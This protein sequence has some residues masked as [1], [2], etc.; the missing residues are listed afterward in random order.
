MAPKNIIKLCEFWLKLCLYIENFIK[1]ALLNVLHNVNNR[2]S[3]QGLPSDPNRLYN[4]LRNHLAK[5][6]KLKDKKIIKSDQWLLLFPVN[7]QTDS[8]KFDTTLIVLLIKNCTTFPSPSEGWKQKLP[9]ATDTTIGAFILRASE[10]RNFIIHYA[11]PDTLEESEF[12]KIWSQGEK[13]LNGLG[14][15]EDT[16]GLKD[17]SL[18]PTRVDY[19]RVFLNHLQCCQKQ[20]QR[21]VD[22]NTTDISNFQGLAREVIE[23][24]EN[25]SSIKDC[26][27]NLKEDVNKGKK[28]LKV[29]IADKINNMLARIHHLNETYE[30]EIAELNNQVVYLE[31]GIKA[32]TNIL[33]DHEERLSKLE[34]EGCHSSFSEKVATDVPSY[35]LFKNHQSNL[36]VKFDEN[37][38]IQHIHATITNNSLKYSKQ[39]DI[40]T[41]YVVE[42]KNGKLLLM[43][44]TSNVFHMGDLSITLKDNKNKLACVLIKDIEPATIH[45]CVATKHVNVL[46]H[47]SSVISK[48]IKSIL[49]KETKEADVEFICGGSLQRMSAKE[50]EEYEKDYSCRYFT[51]NGKCMEEPLQFPPPICNQTSSV[52]AQNIKNVILKLKYQLFTIFTHYDTKDHIQFLKLNE[53]FSL[54]NTVSNDNRILLVFFN[55]IINIRYT[56]AT[57]AIDIQDEFKAGETDLKEL[58]IINRK[59]FKH[60]NWTVINVVAAPNFEI[61]QDAEV[62]INCNLLCKKTLSK[63]RIIRDFFSNI[64]KKEQKKNNYDNSK[65]QYITTVSKIMCFMA[66]RKALYSV[67]SLSDNIHDQ[68]SSLILTIQQLRILYSSYRKKIITGPLGS[69]K[70]V[71]A[72]SHMEL[73]Y[74]HSENNSAIYYVVWDDKTLLKQ[75]VINH[76]KRFKCKKNVE[77]IVTD[78]VELAKNLKMQKVPTPSQL[79]KSL[80]KKHGD[81][82]LHFIIDEFNGEMLGIEEALS[83]KQYFKMEARLADSYIVFLPQSIEKHRS[84]VSHETITKHEKYKYEETGLEFFKLDRAMRTSASI[85]QFLKAFEIKA[86]EKN[87]VIKLPVQE[88]SQKNN[89]PVVWQK[90]TSPLKQED[91]E[92][93]PIR[94]DLSQDVTNGNRLLDKGV[95]NNFEDPIDIDRVAATI[96][97]EHLSEDVRT[98]INFQFNSAAFIGHN[99]KGTK[100][101][102]IHPESNELK[103]EELIA[104]ITLV[105]QHLSL[106]YNTKRLF[107]YN[108]FHQMTIFYRL[109][110]LLDL[111][112][113][114]YDE[115]TDWKIF[116]E[117]EEISNLLQYSSYNILTTPEGCRG[118]E[119]SESIC[120]IENNDRTL[121]HLT[122]ES[123]SRATQNLIIVSTSNINQSKL[124]FSTGHII[125]E[126]L[127][128]YLIE[129][130]V[131]HSKD[132]NT[133]RPYTYSNENNINKVVFNIN[134]QSWQF[135]ELM[136]NIKHIN[137]PQAAPVITNVR[138][139]IF[140]NLHLPG[141]V[142]NVACSYLSDKSCELS[143]QHNAD[144]YT[145]K[146]R[147]NNVSDWKVLAS[148]ITS[149][150]WIVNDISIGENCTFSVVARNRVGQSDDS[151]FSYHHKT[152]AKVE[153]VTYTF[154][155]I[156]KIIKS[157]DINKLKKL[158]SIHPN[159]VHMRDEYERTPLM[160]TVHFTNN[161]SMVEILISYGS[162]VWAEDDEKQNSYHYAAIVGRHTI[163][164]MLCRHDVTNIN[165]GD[166]DNNTPLHWAAINGYISCVDVLLRYENI[167]VTIE[168]EYGYT[169]YD[170]AGRLKNEQN[171]EIIRR[172]IKEYEAR[173][174]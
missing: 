145:V 41:D 165:R 136:K 69:G 124:D 32:N 20:L 44:F 22:E 36:V 37:F 30:K 66:T 27:S 101:L 146:K 169:A 121:K 159:I 105:L 43:I 77:V 150:F 78:I 24:K 55:T 47:N 164:D 51:I 11:N 97:D 63:E 107:I 108:T 80:V 99:I 65:E 54:N 166:D 4:D 28:E 70:T 137:H 10:F 133:D 90:E 161:T 141:K 81:K 93:L 5:L 35:T 85:F 21:I 48:H 140:K 120:L 158:L 96:Q 152:P 148:G 151:I 8:S 25:T 73:A 34:K 104:M 56:D 89:T 122:L 135:K 72:L 113:F 31:R 57:N 39:L 19:F 82:K 64:L 52:F 118:V 160:W 153:D 114:Q 115:Y 129:N 67:P 50:Y 17:N 125:K 9:A 79:F 110:T 144:K 173:K 23:I 16:C 14:Y 100:P 88:A 142:D 71:L 134:T 163:L 60:G 147:S 128:V 119:A 91:Q 170:L 26:I 143:W 123:M 132:L 29:E 61:T 42:R 162:D 130:L 111:D 168:D 155:D 38:F 92:Q 174:K 12:N 102:L 40:D 103:E 59:C 75:D 18:D 106:H 149:N 87:T 167:D 116:K 86:S 172:K 84:F 98:E 112:F 138:K 157:N 58:S 7:Q 74:E 83:L 76:A 139:I 3:Y 126:L 53:E 171:Q 156:V 1:P 15:T 49:K 62:C 154:D 94:Q 46:T 131:T 33:D 13:I 6:T 95:N 117:N 2:G 45:E 68:V 109:L 127:P